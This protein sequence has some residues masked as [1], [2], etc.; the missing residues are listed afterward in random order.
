MYLEEIAAAWRKR[1]ALEVMFTLD[2]GTWRAQGE[3]PWAS[4][5]VAGVEARGSGEVAK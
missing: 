5:K 2:S 1:D 4:S 3:W